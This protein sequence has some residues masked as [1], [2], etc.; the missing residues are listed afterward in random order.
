MWE[1]TTM[2]ANQCQCPL[3]WATADKDANLWCASWS[4][5][6]TLTLRQL[7]WS[8]HSNSE[9]PS[10]NTVSWLLERVS[11]HSG[12]STTSTYCL[13]AGSQLRDYWRGRSLLL[14][15]ARLLQQKLHKHSSGMFC[16]RVTALFTAPQYLTSYHTLCLPARL[17]TLL[18]ICY[19]NVQG[20]LSTRTDI[21]Q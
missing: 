7:I 14:A 6:P 11:R 8:T 5:G 15:Q 21:P 17:Y 13:T 19:R 3:G 20:C 1:P 2:L 16:H 4:V 18:L 12:K 10:S 9:S